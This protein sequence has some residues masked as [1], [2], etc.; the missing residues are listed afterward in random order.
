MKTWRRIWNS[1]RLVQHAGHLF[2]LV[3]RINLCTLQEV[4]SP[5]YRTRPT[6]IIDQRAEFS[7]LWPIAAAMGIPHLEFDSSCYQKNAKAELIAAAIKQIR[8][9]N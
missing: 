3:L 8:K 5:I 2:H 6:R 4:T 1:L 7:Y 9:R